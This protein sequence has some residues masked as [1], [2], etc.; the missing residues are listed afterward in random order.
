MKK[1]LKAIIATVSFFAVLYGA[2]LIAPFCINLES[3]KPEIQKLVKESAKLN[4]DYSSL[5]LYTTPM[6]S[7]G[8]KVED[9]KITLD[10]G[11]LVFST[12]KIKGGVVLP[13]LLTLTVKTS[14]TEVLNPF[15]NLEIINDE[16]YKI[17]RVIENIINENNAK[18]KPQITPEQEKINKLVSLI[19]I[20][21]PAIKIVNYKV[22]IN[23]LKTNNNLTLFG[24]KLY[25]G[26]ISKT[27][28][29]KAQT[30]A[31][32]KSNDKEN[33][34][35]NVDIIA[36]LPMAQQQTVEV[37]PDEK[38]QI[39]FVNIVKIYQTYDLNA[40]INSKI[41]IKNNLGFGYFNIN[42]LNL[43]LSE[44]RL[45]NSFFH[46][47]LKGKKVD[48]DTNLYATNDEKI[49]ILGS[50]KNSKRPKMRLN[51]VS[52]KI[53]FSNL[54]ALLE[55]LLDSLNIK[56]DIKFV[57]ATGYL[58]ADA[59]IKTN[60]KK[61]KSNGTILIKDGSFVNSKNKFGIKDIIAN[62]IFDNNAL[63][64]KDTKA[65]INGAKLAIDGFIDSK[66]NTDINL[67]FNNLSLPILYNAFAPNELK[68]AFN[69]NNANLT[70][71]A[72]IKGKLENLVAKANVALDNL[73]LSDAQ[74]TFYI[75]NKKASVD[76]NIKKDLIDGKISNNEFKFNIP[77]LKTLV[78][79]Q[80]LSINI[81]SENVVINPFDVQYNNSSKINIKGDI[82]NYL[83]NPLID[84]FANGKIHSNDLAQTLGKEIAY[85]VD[86]KGAMPVKAAI[87]GNSKKQDII[88]QI[89]SDANNHFTP[90]EFKSLSN[91]PSLL[92]ANI[93]LNGNKIKIKNSGLFKK[94][95]AT[96][97]DIL[98]ENQNDLTQIVD[99]TMLID[100][101]HL[102]LLRLNI[103]K[104]EHLKVSV[105]KT[106]DMLAKGKVILHGY[107]DKLNF[108]GDVKVSNIKIPELKLALK[109]VDLDFLSN[110]LNINLDKIDVNGSIIDAS[111]KADLAPSNI[112]K[113]KDIN[114]S[115]NLINVDKAMVV[116]Q[117]AMKYMPPASP[118]AKKP[119]TP[120]NIPLLA[121]GKFD[122]KKIT[123]GAIV[124]DNA[125]GNLGIKNND[126]II[127]KLTC[128]GFDG[129]ISGDVKVNLI[130]SLISADVKGK[131]INADK[132]LVQA[133]NMKNTLTGELKFDA[134]ISLKGAT[135][136]EQ[137]K[138]L[139][140]DVSF[141]V[142]DGQ[143]G[144][145]SKLENFF[146]AENVRE[147]PFF[148]NT[149]GIIL[150]PLATVD[151]SHFEKLM[152][153]LSFKN[154][155]ATLNSITSQGDILC[156]LIKGDMDLVKNNLNSN[157]RVRL[158]SAISDMLGPLAMANPVNLVK[159][160]PGLN[161]AS[162]QLFS[163]FTQI[164]EESEY[165]EIPDFAKGHSDNNA[166]KF[167]IVLKG[168]VAKPL[169]LVKSFKWLAVQADM[170]KANEFSANYVQQQLINQLQSEY[171]V[172]NKIKVNAQKVLQMDTTAPAVKELLVDEIIK[173]KQK[174]K[175]VVDT[176]RA[177]LEQKVKNEINIQ[178]EK[179]QE[180]ILDLQNELK[181]KMQEKLKFPITQ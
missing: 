152:G 42:N 27:N 4:L 40:D 79:I 149:I 121:D 160:T 95:N 33:I 173:E 141:E 106:S 83:Q 73:N 16:Q 89:Y 48:F 130:S 108:G 116:A 91:L 2:F 11:S 64:I 74:K 131:N 19:R 181:S 124:I 138:S 62:F 129:T 44:I 47:K 114:V 7:A 50:I 80:D 105:F 143:Y 103:P 5:K 174:A 113:I 59:D 123:T 26:Y 165:K 13:S 151:S 34:K 9:V 15:I 97:S 22:L 142:V 171:E 77:Q 167:Q 178:N 63:N 65:E 67:D 92:Q 136:L 155:I 101:N 146:L 96:F 119:T 18:P 170:E 75:T 58:V 128:K 127:D 132:M 52:D 61:L 156:V 177:E 162:A 166:T 176:A 112:F 36:S 135:Y 25:V 153:E 109:Q 56:N 43:K 10:D 159:N 86:S 98:E 134:D 37:D 126:L 32:L 6:L 172:A 49:A 145:F 72:D 133:A 84:I 28:S 122:I 78:G 69:L 168:D 3:F 71:H 180:K 140:G 68:K 139:K 117:Q 20:K 88:A 100:N 175:A 21:V 14:K 51:I 99:F 24:D 81:D 38:M 57:N 30:N 1:Y 158:A 12:D 161:V 118:S 29:I 179:A 85:Y 76:F 35:A 125:K 120:P 163:V 102:N 45:P 46:A 87:F 144:P 110:S 148:K 90:I 70:L 107:F 154:G 23:D 39:P 164:V 147:N 41:R 53:H 17:V 111:L 55:G 31:I 60:F 157:V 66:A 94:Q 93:A 137:M 115:S 150:T 8:V 82:K 54:L 169:S 104:E